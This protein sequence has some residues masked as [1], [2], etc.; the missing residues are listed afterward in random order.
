MRQ[1]ILTSLL[2]KKLQSLLW[3]NFTL[4]L[5]TIQPK[6]KD[7]SVPGLTQLILILLLLGFSQASMALSVCLYSRSEL[8]PTKGHAFLSIEDTQG[9]V[10]E[11]YAYWPLSTGS[12]SL[13]INKNSDLPLKALRKQGP[14]SERLSKMKEV[15]LCQEVK[16]LRLETIRKVVRTYPKVRGPYKVLTNNCAHFAT[17]MYQT[18]TGDNFPTTQTPKGIGRI[19]DKVHSLQAKSYREFLQ[20]GGR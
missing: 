2:P 16:N 6:P 7:H 18:L 13:A 5:E 4:A 14:L 17:V 1:I 15:R 9:K 3:K 10:L 11:T 19:V 12:E 20:M 8:N